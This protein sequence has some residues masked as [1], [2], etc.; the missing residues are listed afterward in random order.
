MNINVW[1]DDT[2]VVEQRPAV[3]N[4]WSLFNGMVHIVAVWLAAALLRV[5]LFVNKSLG[6]V[7]K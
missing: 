4:R 3:G 2:V 6:N 7:C 5:W 1:D